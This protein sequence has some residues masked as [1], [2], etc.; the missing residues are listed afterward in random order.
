MIRKSICRESM[1]SAKTINKFRNLD[2]CVLD[3][4]NAAHDSNAGPNDI[5]NFSE[6]QVRLDACQLKYPSL[7][8]EKVIKPYVDALNLL[9]EI[10]FDQI[11]LRDPSKQSEA[12]LMLD[13]AQ[14]ILQ[15]GEGYNK[16]ATDALQEVVCDL[17]DGFLSAEDR[18]GIK[19][20]DQETIAPLVKWGDPESGPYTWP[21]E[22]TINFG[23]K[24]AIVS[25]PAANAQRG[26]FAWA[27]L[28]HET[29]GHDIIRADNG[30]NQELKNCLWNA[31][32]DA[33][34]AS[35]LPDYWASRI[36]ET[37]SDVL[38][39][40]NMGPAAGIALIGY[41]R[42]LNAVW[43]E[44]AVLRN[45]GPG[46]DPH[47]ADIL[48]GYLAA[49]VVSL[50][51]FSKAN[52]WAK[53]IEAETDKDLTK[54]QLGE[55]NT[56]IIP[57]EAK[58]SALIAANCLVHTKMECLENHA[59]GEIQNWH[60]EDEAIVKRIRS[61]LRM[62]DPLPELYAKEVYAAHVVAAAIVEALQG[63][64]NTPV[65]FVRMINMLKTLHDKNPSWSSLYM[66]Y[67]G[68]VVP[69]KIYIPF[70]KS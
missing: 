46:N 53:A 38:G 26:I 2:S 8:R 69:L 43:G 33:N 27:A 21:A 17:Y 1:K 48:R 64:T 18:R 62:T 23:V 9:G 58:N 15:H 39:I 55:N 29:A 67:H 52:E 68:N 50:L 57:D 10:E 56:V 25:L 44:G 16:K 42:A 19:L 63:N 22:D 45:V 28:G 60:D 35:S 3:A 40:L 47:L 11:I 41:F 4:Q 37:A 20:P 70:K 66:K 6:L 31:L 30:L 59:L 51:N 14:S 24:T 54:I 5:T 12:R 13:I 65:L 7:Y 34:V 32:Q 36:D 61:I 49:S